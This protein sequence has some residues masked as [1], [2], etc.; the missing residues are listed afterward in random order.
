MFY[1]LDWNLVKINFNYGVKGKEGLKYLRSRLCARL[2][3]NGGVSIHNCLRVMRV[4]VRDMRAGIL[5]P[6]FLHS[7]GQPRKKKF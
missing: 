1:W 7:C 5:L 3:D 4:V 6:L 2:R